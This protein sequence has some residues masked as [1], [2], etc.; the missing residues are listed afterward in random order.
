M[1]NGTF[2]NESFTSSRKSESLNFLKD[3]NEMKPLDKILMIYILSIVVIV[4]FG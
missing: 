2:I 1:A 4:L 3:F